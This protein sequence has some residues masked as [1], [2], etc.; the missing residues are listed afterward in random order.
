MCA[1][2]QQSY[3]PSLR[4]PSGV[5]TLEF[6]SNFGM[7]PMKKLITS[8]ATFSFLLSAAHAGACEGDGDKGKDG[9]QKGSVV[10]EK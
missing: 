7:F 2:W 5:P 9:T 6:S 10:A 1:R 3:T 4:G 8:V